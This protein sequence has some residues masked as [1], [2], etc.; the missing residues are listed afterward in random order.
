MTAPG[1]DPGGGERL[2]CHKCGSIDLRLYESTREH[3][4]W[5]DGVMVKDGELYP[6][7]EAEHRTGDILTA[8]TR[9]T[10]QDCAHKWR[11][12]RPVSGPWEYELELLRMEARRG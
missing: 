2:A 12:R 4:T 3:H 8:E 7:G 1:A 11:P 9:L 10:C 6:M 5:P